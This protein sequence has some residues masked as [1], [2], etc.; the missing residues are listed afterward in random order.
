[1]SRFGTWRHLASSTSFTTGTCTAFGDWIHVT[2]QCE[3]HGTKEVKQFRLS[4]FSVFWDCKLSS[5]T[6]KTRCTCKAGR[7]WLTL[8]VGMRPE[9]LTNKTHD[10]LMTPHKQRRIPRGPQKFTCSVGAAGGDCWTLIELLP[11][12]HLVCLQTSTTVIPGPDQGT[13]STSGLIQ[14]S[15]WYS[16]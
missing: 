2:W 12:V 3:R 7:L 8:C 1:M 9:R 11:Q 14:K 4:Y 5:F 15:N 16:T 10:E 6:M 13:F